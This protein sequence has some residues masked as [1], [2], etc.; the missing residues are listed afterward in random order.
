[1][2]RSCCLTLAHNGIL[3]VPCGQLWAPLHLL[4]FSGVRLL[5]YQTDGWSRHSHTCPE[6]T[7]SL[8]NILLCWTIG[9]NWS[10][11]EQKY[12]FVCII[13]I[14][15]DNLQAWCQTWGQAYNVQF[16]LTFKWKPN[17]RG[18]RKN[19]SRKDPRLMLTE[20]S[21]SIVE[22]KKMLKRHDKG[23]LD[24]MSVIV[25]ESGNISEISAVQP[26]CNILS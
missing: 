11:I 18:R 15:H 8:A 20:T 19:E 25:S 17:W 3:K 2:L 1:M 13:S 23:S 4:L 6:V 26:M 9:Q 16:L 12:I 24:L 22:P 5:T 21:H 10:V 7:C 14:G